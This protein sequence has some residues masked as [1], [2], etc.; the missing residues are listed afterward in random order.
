MILQ[1]TE[2]S[3][4]QEISMAELNYNPYQTKYIHTVHSWR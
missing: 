3:F 4:H 2:F 1:M